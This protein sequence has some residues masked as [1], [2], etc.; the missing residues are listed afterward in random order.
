MVTAFEILSDRIKTR[1]VETAPTVSY[2]NPTASLERQLFVKLIEKLTGQRRLQRIYDDYQK[3]HPLTDNF[4]RDAVAW[5]NLTVK[6]DCQS[7]ARIPKT[8]PLVVVANHPFGILDG[9]VLAYLISLVRT[10]FKIIA[11]AVLGRAREIV[12]Y[13][14][15]IQFQGQITAPTRENIRAKMLAQRHVARGGALLLFPAGSV[16]TANSVFGPAT[17]APWKTFASKV[18][19]ATQAHVVPIYFEGKN[20]WVF[21]LASRIH[22][23]LREAFLLREVLLRV[24]G[25]INAHIGQAINPE[26]LAAIGNKQAVVD[27]LREAVYQAD[28]QNTLNL[29]S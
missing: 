28:T 24:G 27:Y 1:L 5:L 29:T 18:I 9:I 23:G 20:S 12:P 4:W 22:S 17:D 7:L 8:G 2:F 11:H 19:L 21:H 10:D 16:S 14:I 13:L 3:C 6:Y 25:R 26:D 15:P